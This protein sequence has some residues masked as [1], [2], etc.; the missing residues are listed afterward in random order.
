MR[1]VTENPASGN[2]PPEQPYEQ[3]LY[4]GLYRQVHG[5]AQSQDP[6]TLFTMM[7]RIFDAIEYT[8][9]ALKEQDPPSLA[10]ACSAGCYYCCVVQVQVLPIEALHLANHLKTNR[11]K[12][13]IEALTSNLTDFG[14][15]VRGLTPNQQSALKMS[16]PF[17]VDDMCSVYEARPVACRSAN[18]TDAKKCQAALEPEVSLS[19]VETYLHQSKICRQA[20]KALA[21]AL[22]D[23]GLNSA[24]LELTSAVGTALGHEDAVGAWRRGEPVFDNSQVS[25]K[26]E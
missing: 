16:C 10:P 18:S 22:G 7:G 3:P 11:S 20:S 2:D 5:S 23:C 12:E 24:V 6:A 1:A 17:L 8:L 15:K 13:E 26:L 19:T 25:V 14:A 21:T 9:K 4:S